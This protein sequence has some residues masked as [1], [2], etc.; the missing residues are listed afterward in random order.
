MSMPPERPT[1][2][3]PSHEEYQLPELTSDAKN[4]AVICHLAGLLGVPV[5]LI[6]HVIGPLV[7]WLLKRDD[8]PF[9]DHQ[10][11]EAVNF[12]ISIVI[13]GILLAIT[14]IG[15]PLAIALWPI[16]VVLVIIAAVK[17]SSG[18]PFRYPLTI[19]LIK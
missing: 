7:V 17:S 8:H 18:E 19:R 16:D 14:C 15:I 12:Q 6:G 11:R 4:W 9:I 3:Y 1:E 5:P 13:Y 2:P 10:G